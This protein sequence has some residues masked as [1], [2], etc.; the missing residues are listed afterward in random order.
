MVG[1]GLRRKSGTAGVVGG[2]GVGLGCSRRRV[3]GGA[4]GRGKVGVGVLVKCKESG[5][6]G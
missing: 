3:G 5:V 4:V 6:R 1:L 2:G